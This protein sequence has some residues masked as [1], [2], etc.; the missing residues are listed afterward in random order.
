M[1]QIEDAEDKEEQRED[2][3]DTEEEE[4]GA[5]RRSLSLISERAKLSAMVTLCALAATQRQEDREDEDEA[6]KA[7]ELKDGTPQ[8]ALWTEA[9]ALS[10]HCFPPDNRR[11]PASSRPRFWQEARETER[12][13][14]GSSNERQDHFSVE[15]LQ[16]PEEEPATIQTIRPLGASVSIAQCGKNE[17][18]G[19]WI[20]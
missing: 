5:S 10:W 12:P 2:K 4:E 14:Q 3:E 15:V 7:E 11:Q 6:A 16:S 18:H 1:P 17:G 8:P 20:W 19:R 9:S 13:A